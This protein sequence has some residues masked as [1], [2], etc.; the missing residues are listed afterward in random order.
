MKLQEEI[1]RSEELVKVITE[2]INQGKLSLKRAEETIVKFINR[3]G[4][5]MIDELVEHIDEPVEDNRVI[6]N[7]EEAV[8]DGIRNLR[9]RNRFGGQTVRA[10]R[11]YKFVNKEGGW[12][13]L[14]EKLGIGYEGGFS[15]LMTYLEALYGASEPYERSEQLLSESI[16]FH[17]SATA[18][19]RNTEMTGARIDGIPYRM[20][21]AEKREESCELMVVEIDGTM[22]PQIREKEGIAGRKSLSEPTEY[23]ECNL[24]VV[25]KYTAGECRDRWVG[26][27]YGPRR[28][29]DDY[30]RRTGIQM[31]QL[32]A[33]EGAFVA[34]GAKTNWEIQRTNFPEATAIL[35][36]YHATEHLSEFC[37]LFSGAETSRRGYKK[38]R[39]MLL[40]GEV[41][42][43][44]AE[45]KESL[46]NISDKNKG[47]GEIN[48]FENNRDRMHYKDY[49]NRGFP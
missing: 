36:F 19:Q 6:V 28:G 30:V 37:D 14:D 25:E 10:R 31:G 32:K 35:D 23:K 48:Y 15:P 40:E 26:A 34:D 20:I 21:P 43:V 9:F 2:G 27:C 29:F 5:I 38:W 42:Q 12:Y 39:V 18:I 1:L 11:C 16:G 44:I 4:Q 46:K 41:L 7:G 8:F 3:I 45:M 17:V 24:I 49:R 22:S 13:P 47:W 33:V